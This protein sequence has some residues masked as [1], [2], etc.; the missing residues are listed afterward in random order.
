MA[1]W[2]RTAFIDFLPRYL[3]IQRPDP[4]PSSEDVPELASGQ[5]PTSCAGVTSSFTFPRIF[6]L[7]KLVDFLYILS[8]RHFWLCIIT[9]YVIKIL[10][11]TYRNKT[12]KF[13]W[14]KC[15]RS[16]QFDSARLPPAYWPPGSRRSSFLNFVF[17]FHSSSKSFI[18]ILK[19][20]SSVSWVPALE[21]AYV[22][23]L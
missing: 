23:F 19:K 6:S 8:W 14:K 10:F 1:P 7:W 18:S 17:T 5:L 11:Y 22:A 2:V 4:D 12:D 3:F 16:F 15:L 13:P 9:S 21:A 20:T